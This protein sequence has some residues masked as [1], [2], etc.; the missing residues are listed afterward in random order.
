MAD[1]TSVKVD[2]T[3]GV[4]TVSFPRIFPSTAGKKDDGSPSFDI[5]LLIPKSDRETARAILTAIKQVGESKWGDKWKGA[6][7]PLRDGDREK[8]ELTEDGS[9]KGE[10]YPERL[11]HWF[12][13]ARSTKPVGVYDRQRN[14]ITNPDDVY[15]GCKA[16]VAVTFYAYS[17]SGNNGI[18]VGLNGV[19]KIA[20]G[21]PL[22]S[23]KPNVESMFD[24]LDEDDDELGLDDVD[25]IEEVEEA[26][27]KRAPAKKA[28]AKKAPAKR[29]AR[30]PEPVDIEE[31]E[32]DLYDDLEDDI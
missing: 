8:D 20:D 30:K 12:L 3:T 31:D 15:A 28:V 24:L 1:K 19:Q 5:Q 6:R 22:G 26:P 27:V 21:Q 4:G 25:E 17:V 18:G 23:A 32:D 2:L 16:K 10:K 29:A 11:G 9:S 7:T 13:N 14:L